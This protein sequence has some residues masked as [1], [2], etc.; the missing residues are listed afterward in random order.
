MMKNLM[1]EI[2]VVNNLVIKDFSVKNLLLEKLM[3]IHV[4]I[5]KNGG[6]KSGE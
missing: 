5:K 4:G 2:S 1:I 6:E 3:T